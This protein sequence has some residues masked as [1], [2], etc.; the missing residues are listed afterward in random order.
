GTTILEADAAVSAQPFELPTDTETTR[1]ITRLTR[2]ASI[3]RRIRHKGQRDGEALDID[4]A[5]A[6]TIERRAGSIS[7]PRVYQRDAPGPRD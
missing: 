1:W 4:A 3:G 2:D 7:E 5:I 6:L